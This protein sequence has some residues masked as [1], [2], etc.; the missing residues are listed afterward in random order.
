MLAN[1][2]AYY[3]TFVL[4]KLFQNNFYQCR[5]ILSR[6][7]SEVMTNSPHSDYLYLFLVKWL[8]LHQL[9]IIPN[10]LSLVKNFAFE[11]LPSQP[12]DLFLW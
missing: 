7:R 12:R 8:A 3:P 5:N 1:L 11:A 10:V 9:M 2:A 4:Y 6:E